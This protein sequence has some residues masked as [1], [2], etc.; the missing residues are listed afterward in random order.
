MADISPEAALARE[1][2]GRGRAAVAAIA[3]GAATLAGGIAEHDR[4]QPAAERL[5]RRHHAA[6]GAQRL[7]RRPRPAPRHPRAAGRVDRRARR[8][9][10]ARRRP[11]RDRVA[12]RCSSRCATCS[13]RSRHATRRW[14]ARASSRR[15]RGCI[16]SG[17]GF[18]VY[19]IAFSLDAKSFADEAVQTSGAA[20]DAISGSAVQAATVIYQLGRFGLALAL[21]IV[22]PQ[23]DAHRPARRG[24]SACSGSLSGLLLVLPIDQPG[25]IR[26]FFLIALGL[27]FL[28]KWHGGRPP[29]WQTGTAQP[30]PSQQEMRGAARG[31][32]RGEE[33]EATPADDP[34]RRRA[35]TSRRRATT[36]RRRSRLAQARARAASPALG[37][38]AR[39]MRVLYGVNGEGMGH[40]TRSEVAIGSLLG[41]GHDVRVMASGAA[42]R[43]LG[44]RLGD[45]NE[46][47]GP[48]FAME[49]GEI[50]RWATVTHTMTAARARA[51]RQRAALDGR[52]PRVAARGRGH[53]L[54]AALRASTR[55]GRTSRWSASTTST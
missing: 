30:W 28:G 42:F 15:S 34:T 51:A 16:A 2:E 54:R 53:R 24:S 44:G 23:R 8:R 46:F 45:V 50:R 39:C 38:V 18:L 48:S 40:A 36:T 21:V 52:R 4:Q 11:R 6:A 47:F 13:W 29:A 32:R 41:D 20:R 43:Y 12:A 7:A 14:G 31:P 35:T 17:V 5:R 19:T 9:P 1:E 3:A 49:Q 27:M 33:P 37:P 22:S 25:I 55:A 26:S 10:G